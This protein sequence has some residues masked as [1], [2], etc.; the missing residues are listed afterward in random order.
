[1]N[2]ANP[3][4]NAILTASDPISVKYAVSQRRLQDGTFGVTYETNDFSMNVATRPVTVL[5]NHMEKVADASLI[6]A[7]IRKNTC[8]NRIEAGVFQ[9]GQENERISEHGMDPVLNI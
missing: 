8:Q 9:K 7:I 5:H 1:M 4:K 3:L 6:E 2:V